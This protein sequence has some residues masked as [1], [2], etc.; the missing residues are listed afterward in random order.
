MKKLIFVIPIALLISSCSGIFLLSQFSVPFQ[1]SSRDPKLPPELTKNCDEFRGTLEYKGKS[2][3][4]ISKV[5]DEKGGGFPISVN[6]NMT[7]KVTSECY[8]NGVQ[9]GLSKR[10]LKR[11]TNNVRIYSGSNEGGTPLNQADYTE[12][13]G[14][15]PPYIE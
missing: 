13:S 6:D 2:Y 11:S 5:G 10:T 14:A 3:T 7:W 15:Y 1:F 4:I 9:T 8:L 12:I